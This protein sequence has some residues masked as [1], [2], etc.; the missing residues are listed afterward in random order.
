MPVKFRSDSSYLLAGGLGGIGRGLARWMAEHGARHLVFLSRSTNKESHQELFRELQSI[1]CSVTAI[2]GSVCSLSDVEKAIAV[3]PVPLRGIFNLSMTLS[4]ASLLTMTLAEW[5]AAR[6]PKVTGTWN[7]HEA[8]YKYR[9]LDFFVLFSSMCGII[10]MPGQANYASANTFMDA[11]VQYRRHHGLPASVIDI[12]AVEGIGHVAE[13]PKI[14][15]RSKWLEGV[16][17][18]QREL[19]QAIS[20]AIKQSHP[21]ENPAEQSQS[22]GYVSTAQV[23]TGFRNS[24]NLNK[25]FRNNA[26]FLDRR[27]AIYSNLEDEGRDNT[28]ADETQLGVALQRFVSGLSTAGCDGKL[29]DQNTAVVLAKEISKWIFDLLL[30]PVQDDSEIDLVRSLTDIGFD[31]LAAVELQSWYKATLGLEISVLEIMS[32]ESLSALGEHALRGL[33]AKFA[34]A[35]NGE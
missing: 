30:K 25:A 3:T 10:G 15:E 35:V 29:D 14:L 19:F 7:L 11:F 13:N 20:I 28:G 5:E 4:D 12:G 21:T 16:V 18:S 27:L 34:C 17:M 1:G 8:S 32:S 9:E 26:A 33:K 22:E 31:S 24:S 2:E 23:I 6:A